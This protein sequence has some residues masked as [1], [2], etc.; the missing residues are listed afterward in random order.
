MW[1]FTPY[2]FVSVV[3]DDDGDLVV[4]ARRR[5]HLERLFPNETIVTTRRSD[6]K[7]RVFVDRYQLAKTVAGWVTSIDYDNFKA[8]TGRVN[9]ELAKLYGDV[10]ALGHDY[11]K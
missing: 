10:W 9:H 5:E 4:R 1:I 2:G 8:E 3:E 7:Y 6:Y 11:Q